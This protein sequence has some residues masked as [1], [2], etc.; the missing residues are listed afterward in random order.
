MI[1]KTNLSGGENVTPE[2]TAQTPIIKNIMTSLEGK[3]WEDKK[4]LYV[5]KKYDISPNTPLEI[6]A[7]QQ[8]ATFVNYIGYLPFVLD[9]TN[10]DLSTV[11]INYFFNMIFQTTSISSEPYTIKDNGFGRAVAISG[12]RTYDVTWDAPTK[13][14]T[15][16][17]GDTNF[18]DD[19][20]TWT[21][22]TNKVLES[23]FFGYV[24]SDKENSYPDGG[25]QGGYWYEKASLISDAIPFSKIK[26]GSF[27]PASDVETL[28]IPHNIGEPVKFIYIIQNNNASLS[29][30]YYL[31]L[32]INMI[33]KM[34]AGTSSRSSG[35]AFCCPSDYPL[36][37]SL[38]PYTDNG[39]IFSTTKELYNSITTF[40]FKSGVEYH[41]IA[42]A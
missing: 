14:L 12:S 21:V 38:N 40:Y 3:V 6:T 11:S 29:G 1:G 25:T 10:V 41:W 33:V 37:S 4:G 8:T 22:T 30:N 15:F 19:I 16:S 20:H 27:T 13:T 26:F 42:M 9:S 7:I 36:G 24:V 2:V 23:T 17:R 18:G 28:S 39:F 31:S 35:S 34:F 5:W 32:E